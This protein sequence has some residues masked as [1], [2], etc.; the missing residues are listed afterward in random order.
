MK[1]PASASDNYYHLFM[2]FKAA[3]NLTTEK[4]FKAITYMTPSVEAANMVVYS[5]ANGSIFGCILGV[6]FMLQLVV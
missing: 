4:V 5:S 2:S 3:G 6:V 1:I